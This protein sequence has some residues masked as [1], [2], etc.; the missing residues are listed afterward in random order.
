MPSVCVIARS[1]VNAR[2]DALTK[3]ITLFA[4]GAML[5]TVC[6]VTLGDEKPAAQAHSPSAWGLLGAHKACVIFREYRKTK[7]GF[8][9]VV[10]TAKTHSELEVIETTDAYVMDPKKWIED[11]A[12]MD[13]LQHRAY[14][15]GLR[16]VK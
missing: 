1:T 4:V 12:T 15:D 16:Y 3:A 7:V 5:T 9:V 2:F 10:I 8:F 13:Q 6:D 11:E 14:K